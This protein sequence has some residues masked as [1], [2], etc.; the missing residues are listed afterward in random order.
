VRA[1]II[2]SQHVGTAFVLRRV[3]AGEPAFVEMR[4]RRGGEEGFSAVITWMES[5]RPAWLDALDA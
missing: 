1:A 5:Q 2:E 4:R 3:E